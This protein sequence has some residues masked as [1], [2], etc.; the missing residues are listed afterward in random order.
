[1]IKVQQATWEHL[2]PWAELRV[3]LW[4]DRSVQHHQNDAVRTFL[5]GNDRA[6]AFICQTDHEQLVGFAEATLRSDYV[7]GCKTSP[8]LFL[9]GVYVLPDY[10][11]MGVA[12]LLH[13]A[14][15]EWGRSIGCSELA[16]DA[17]LGNTESHKFHE[18]M[19]FRE[20]ERVVFFR[21]DI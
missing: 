3:A 18:A 14:V 21:K 10:R 13:D 17:P 9:E 11:R 7:N 1:M 4:P 5:N 6:V 2:K 15:A 19:G 20:T 16:S 8:V 12:T